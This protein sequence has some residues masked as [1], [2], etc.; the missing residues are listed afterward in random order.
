MNTLIAR[1]MPFAGFLAIGLLSAVILA[2]L[3]GMP[4]IAGAQSETADIPADLAGVAQELQCASRAACE[5][6]CNANLF[7]CIEVSDRLN[8][9]SSEV[10]ELAASFK[11][12]VLNKL[13][14]VS[15]ENF[16]DRI[17]EIARELLRKSPQLAKRLDVDSA[18]VTAAETIFKEV[19][20]AGVDL[21]VC[22]QPA[23]SLSR[24]QLIGCVTASKRLVENSETF[25]PYI[26]EDRLKQADASDSLLKAQ[27]DGLLAGCGNGTLE[28]CGE[29]CF[30]PATIAK[31]ESAIPEVCLN[32]ARTVFKDEGGEQALRDSYRQVKQAGDHYLARAS[33]FIFTTPDGKT[34][35]GKDEIRN[36]CESAFESKDIALAKACGEFG[37]KNGFISREEMEEGLSFMQS[38][39]E[40]GGGNFD[41]RNCRENPQS[42][43]QFIPDDRKQEFQ[44]MKQIEDA[45][46]A[47]IG[48]DP[49]Q[50]AAAGSDPSIGQKCLEGSKRALQKLEGTPAAGNPDVRR[51]LVAGPHEVQCE[52]R[53]AP[54]SV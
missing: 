54:L 21:G 5:A 11:Q 25:K 49:R 39:V 13:T 10:D 44:A 45:V 23:E 3:V 20:N 7:K 34:L 16:E 9:Y 30:D 53:D 32:L 19:K 35:A 40:R 17:I 6:A 41:F 36:T 2:G 12:E 52:A 48:F 46:R 50:C 38:V 24:E 33:R 4:G 8:V 29:F 31:G 28:S 37:V 42:C 47:E 26:R 51:L 14:N 15:D 43:E 18:K 27:Q 22:S 1:R